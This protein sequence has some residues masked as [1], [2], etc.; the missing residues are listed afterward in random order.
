V[1]VIRTNSS[2]DVADNL[3]NRFGFVIAAGLMQLVVS[4]I[5]IQLIRQLAD[6]HMKAIGEV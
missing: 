1:S 4:V 5:F 2:N 6:R 3:S